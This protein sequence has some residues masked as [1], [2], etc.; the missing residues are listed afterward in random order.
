[1][2]PAH[3]ANITRLVMRIHSWSGLLGALVF[4]VVGLSG[5]VLVFH[6][7]LDA[8]LFPRLFKVDPAAG[9]LSYQR[10]FETAQRAFPE[11]RVRGFR[12]PPP[13]EP[14]TLA[15]QAVGPRGGPTHIALVDPYTGELRGTRIWGSGHTRFFDD[16]VSWVYLLHYQLTAG[17]VGQLVVV[18]AAILLALSVVTGT[19]VYRKQLLRALMLRE[20]LRNKGW[21]ARFSSLHRMVGVWTLALNLLLAVSGLWM[22]RATF[23]ADFW[24]RPDG[25]PAPTGPA[26]RSAHT[27][28]EAIAAARRA[29]PDLEPSWVELRALPTDRFIVM[30]RHARESKLYGRYASTVTLD[31]SN[32]GVLDVRRPEALAL[33]GKL[34]VLAFPLHQGHW[35]GLPVRLLYV[36]AGLGVPM[37]S[38]TGMLLWL[39][40]NRRR[41]VQP[42]TQ[43]GPVARPPVPATGTPKV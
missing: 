15:V 5:A 38:L 6:S 11:A 7:E 26:P 1:M 12:V 28:D 30:G 9:E 2:P 29:V 3:R 35:G 25:R 40:R 4:V 13:G 31:A 41:R 42:A 14:K 32:L 43:P 23:T 19:F 20:P 8:A 22:L 37:L 27:F 39:R 16:P 36:L 17:Q 34:D 24:K 21:M 33:G 10:A 18:L